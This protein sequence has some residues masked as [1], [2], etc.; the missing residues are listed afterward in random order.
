M[1]ATC[2]DYADAL[3]ADTPERMVALAARARVAE[4]DGDL[5]WLDGDQALRA[6]QHPPGG[7][8]RARWMC[9]ACS[10][11]FLLEVGSCHVLGDG[12]RPLIGN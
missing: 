8:G 12:W 10:R 9:S 1:C 5:E 3:P 2:D 7:P 6:G 11:L 4:A